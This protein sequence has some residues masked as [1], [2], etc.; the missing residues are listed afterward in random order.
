MERAV[1]PSV[2]ASTAA[3]DPA[4]RTTSIG[5]SRVLLLASQANATPAAGQTSPTFIGPTTTIRPRKP[6]RTYAVSHSAVRSSAGMRGSRNS[7]V[8]TEFSIVRV[9]H[10]C[11]RFR[12]VATM[13]S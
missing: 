6:A 5:K 12:A 7:A 13:E 2:S 4:I 1:P 3:L 10:V 11:E 9:D 8:T